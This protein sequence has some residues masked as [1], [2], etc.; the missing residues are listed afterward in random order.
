M[1]WKIQCVFSSREIMLAAKKKNRS[2]QLA[3]ELKSDS[4]N[5]EFLRELLMPS[6]GL[7]AFHVS[8]FQLD[9]VCIGPS[10]NAG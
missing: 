9:L 7:K 6:Q 4:E 1:F 2:H 10:V 8:G 3:K 5:W